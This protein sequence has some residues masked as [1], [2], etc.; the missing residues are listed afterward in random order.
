MRIRKQICTHSCCC[1]RSGAQECTEG[2]SGW[3]W[4][5]VG[6]VCAPVS[7]STGD[8]RW[9]QAVTEKE[10]LQIDLRPRLP[11]DLREIQHCKY[12][13]LLV[14]SYL[15]PSLSIQWVYGVEKIVKKYNIPEMHIKKNNIYS[16]VFTQKQSNMHNKT[17]KTSSNDHSC[18]L[19]TVYHLLEIW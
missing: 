16:Q 9:D 2:Q 6:I 7:S 18:W 4:P 3:C 1:V 19:L 10:T 11:M 15:S 17:T 12:T 8:R 13:V 5:V 14:Q